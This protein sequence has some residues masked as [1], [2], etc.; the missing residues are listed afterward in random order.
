MSDLIEISVVVDT[1]A[2]EVVT[3][4]QRGGIMGVADWLARKLSGRR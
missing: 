1:E 2:A 3:A 4:H